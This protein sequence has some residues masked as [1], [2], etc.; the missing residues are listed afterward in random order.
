MEIASN[1]G[2]MLRNFVQRGV[3][4]LGIDPAPGPAAAAERAGIRTLR[5]YFGRDLGGQLADDGDRADVI[6]ANNVLAHVSDLNGFVAGIGLLLKD[7]G[8]AVFE[9]PYVRDLVDK[10]EFDTMYH[11]HLCYFSVTALNGLF[12]RHGL[13]LHRVEHYPVHG[14]SLRIHVARAAQADNTVERYL[15]SERED[16]V[17]RLG[18]YAGFGD[19]VRRVRDEVSAMLVGFRRAGAVVAAYGAAAKGSTLLNYMGFDERV[20]RFV[21]DRNPHKHDLFMPGV[22][23]PVSH[24]V[25][26]LEEMP[27]YVLLLAW[28]FADEILEQQAE[29]RHRGGRFVIPIPEPR[30]V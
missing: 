1:D 23:Q 24:P 6:I 8:V 17:D 15:S 3:P 2:Y 20:V 28:N 21:V 26:L 18:F 30:L 10:C 29:Y 4:V 13:V 11:E 7:E 14:G 9:A 16:G 5:R 12:A 27:D 22:H 25:R 19:R